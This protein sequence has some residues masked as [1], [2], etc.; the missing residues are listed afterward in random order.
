ML[1]KYLSHFKN[2]VKRK[3]I[4]FSEKLFHDS[5]HLKTKNKSQTIEYAMASVTAQKT[6]TVHPPL[7]LVFDKAFAYMF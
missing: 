4:I 2:Q 3:M 5:K 6:Q 7:H 1:S